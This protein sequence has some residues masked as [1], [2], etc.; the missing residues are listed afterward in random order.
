MQNKIR[1]I[2]SMYWRY[3]S[4][5]VY[6]LY[7]S[8]G[9]YLNHSKIEMIFQIILLHIYYCRIHFLWYAIINTFICIFIDTYI[10]TLVHNG[11]QIWF[12]YIF[13]KPQTCYNSA[14]LIFKYISNQMDFYFLHFIGMIQFHMVLYFTSCIQ[15]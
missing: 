14:F 4:F 11:H 13:T 15:P 3:V 1:Q 2:M 9:K 12:V 7:S 10:H 8:L 5:K 6:I